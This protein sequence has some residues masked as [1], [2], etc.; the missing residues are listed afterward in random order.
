MCAHAFPGEWPKRNETVVEIHVVALDYGHVRHRLAR[1]RFAFTQRPV[2]DFALGDL[3]GCVV[4]ERQGDEV[5]H[6]IRQM[7]F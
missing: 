3:I 7:P 4:R 2:L 1:N 5:T 6:R